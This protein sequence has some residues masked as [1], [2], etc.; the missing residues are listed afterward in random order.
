MPL[1]FTTMKDHL[2]LP[3]GRAGPVEPLGQVVSACLGEFE[4]FFSSVTVSGPSDL[5]LVNMLLQEL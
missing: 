2:C 5:E 1:P 3:T 4:V